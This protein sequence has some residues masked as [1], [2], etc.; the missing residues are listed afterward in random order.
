[1]VF[2]KGGSA[3]KAIPTK[4]ENLCQAIKLVCGDIGSDHFEPSAGLKMT[5]KL[6]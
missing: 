2:F 5:A 4:T 6:F 1:L 3:A